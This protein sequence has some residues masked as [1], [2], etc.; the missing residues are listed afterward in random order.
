MRKVPFFLGVFSRDNLPIPT[1]YPFS[2]ITNTDLQTESGT[3]WIAFYVDQHGRGMY[4]DSYANKPYYP[5]FVNYL[6]HNCSSG[7]D[8][9]RVPLQCTTCSTCGEY[10]CCYI[11]LRTSDFTHEQYLQ[12]FGDNTVSNDIIVKELFKVVQ[13]QI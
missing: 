3:H 5:E 9:N 13:Y 10:C 7:Y 12:F 2:L 4:F 8:W 11:I 1:S 6:N